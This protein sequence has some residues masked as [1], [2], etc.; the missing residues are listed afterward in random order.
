CRDD[1]AVLG[2]FHRVVADPVLEEIA[3]DV[4]RLGGARLAREEV[5]EQLRDVGA[6]RAQVQVGD[7]EGRH[8]RPPAYFF[9]FTIWNFSIMTSAS[10]TSLKPSRVPVGMPLI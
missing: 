8:P 9:G 1:R 10:G 5:E 3:E 6:L 7:E 4:E 2:L